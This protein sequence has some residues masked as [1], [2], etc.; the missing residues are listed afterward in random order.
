M[1]CDDAMQDRDLRKADG[2]T[3]LLMS[4]MVSHAGGSPDGE[5][6]QEVLSSE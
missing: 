5:L 6:P 1:Q 3:T 4:R 2:A